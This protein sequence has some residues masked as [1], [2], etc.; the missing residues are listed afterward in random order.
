[1]KKLD[2][3][4]TK[5][6]DLYNQGLSTIEI[7]K[8]FNC[9]KQAIN[10][11]LHNKRNNIKDLTGQ[12]F[13]KLTVIQRLNTQ[14]Y[15]SYE[16]QCQCECGKIVTVTT[17]DL[18]C[19]RIK[20]CGDKS[21][22]TRKPTINRKKPVFTKIRDI[23]KNKNPR[24][25]GYKDIPGKFWSNLQR[26]ATSRNKD[27]TINIEYLQTLWEQQNG[28]CAIS[29]L[30]I[31]FGKNRTASLDRKDSKHGYVIGNVQWIHSMV[32]LMKYNYPQDKFIAM[33]KTISDNNK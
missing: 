4:E 28:I 19:G 21:C 27:F 10:K 7:A 15:K 3:P 11:R 30:K 12:K 22:L 33:C 13:H 23:S 26:E 32:N 14:K 24:W 31:E 18:S 25:K 5:I 17:H 1:M 20:C 29:G 9:S 2:L 8:I 6:N 16:N